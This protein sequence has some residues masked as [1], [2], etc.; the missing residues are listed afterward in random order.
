MVLLSCLAAEFLC[1]MCECKGD[2]NTNDVSI[3]NLVALAVQLAYE[4]R[5]DV[6]DY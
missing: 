5:K 4:V 3:S 2:D 1:Q 6:V